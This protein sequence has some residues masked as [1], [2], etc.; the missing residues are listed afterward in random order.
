ME[1]NELPNIMHKMSEAQRVDPL[2]NPSSF[3]HLLFFDCALLVD[4]LMGVVCLS[5]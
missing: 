2:I 4:R 3:L 5:P 1:I